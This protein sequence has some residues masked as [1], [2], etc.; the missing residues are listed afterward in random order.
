MLAIKVEGTFQ[1]SMGKRPALLCRELA[2]CPETL[3]PTCVLIPNA[4]LDQ[5]A[6]TSAA[7]DTC[8]LSGLFNGSIVPETFALGAPIPDGSCT[9]S[10]PCTTDGFRCSYSRGAKF[11]TCLQGADSCI[12]LGECYETTC[13]TC[14]DCITKANT[15]VAAQLQRKDAATIA[16]A[17][18]SF[19]GSQLTRATAA[20]CALTEAAIA[21][22][23][24]GNLGKRAAT[25]C[26]WVKCTCGCGSQGVGCVAC[27]AATHSCLKA[28]L[29]KQHGILFSYFCTY[30]F[31]LRAV[32][33]FAFLS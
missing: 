23:P 12:P 7:L 20:D 10:Q 26:S 16:A 6:I 15:F 31:V 3:D 25:L 24:Y 2:E 22:S 30:N 33:L 5:P 18:K 21:A 17:W 32:L 11:C 1:G 14:Q 29:S 9:S 13:T 27:F 28:A 19:C 4:T 8:S